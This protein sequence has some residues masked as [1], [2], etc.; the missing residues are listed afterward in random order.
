M[1]ALAM[2]SHASEHV[3][4]AEGNAS[5]ANASQEPINASV[6]QRFRSASVL[7][8]FSWFP[9]PW[10]IGHLVQRWGLVLCGKRAW[11][12]IVAKPVMSKHHVL[13]SA[14]EMSRAALNTKA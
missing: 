2:L 5:C 11:I 4:S 14:A 12:T 7:V 13:E 9:F 3:Q 6:P 1:E 10:K 8:Q